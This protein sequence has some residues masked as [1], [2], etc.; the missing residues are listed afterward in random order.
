[1]KAYSRIRIFELDQHTTGFALGLMEFT[2]IS[3]FVIG[4]W[5]S[6]YMYH[7]M[8]RTQV[9]DR[10]VDEDINL[11]HLIVRRFALTQPEFAEL[12]Q[13][14][15]DQK[16]DSC[17]WVRRPDSDNLDM[18]PAFYPLEFGFGMPKNK[19]SWV[20]LKWAGA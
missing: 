14:M 10:L 11:Q 1:M 16:L 2:E 20:A 5:E 8:N 9:I 17:F 13:W 6:L 18:H 15:K 3:K 7:G 12:R 4:E 19:S